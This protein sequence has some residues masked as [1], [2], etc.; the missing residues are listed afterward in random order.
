MHRL[1]QRDSF[2]G[3]R[4]LPVINYTGYLNNFPINAE[5]HLVLL[6]F[7]ILTSRRTSFYSIFIPSFQLAHL[8][9]Y[10][11]IYLLAR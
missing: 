1:A 2:V 10:L 4:F 6:D 7:S 11:F 8:L 3:Y 5:R 9:I